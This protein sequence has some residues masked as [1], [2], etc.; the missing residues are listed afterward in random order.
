M[1]HATIRKSGAQRGNNRGAPKTKRKAWHP[2][3]AWY[4]A[5]VENAADAFFL[6]DFEGRYLAV[7]NQACKSLGYA[8]EELLSM[9]VTDVEMEYTL[10]KLKELWSSIPD[11]QPV[12]VEGHHRRKDGSLFDIEARIVPA[13]IGGERLYLV[14]IR[15]IA[16]RRAAE[17]RMALT[18]D[19]LRITEKT[20]QEELVRLKEFA[21]GTI[22]GL[23]KH[24]CVL[25][26]EGTIL[27]VNRA[28]RQFADANP[29][30]PADYFLGANYL[31]VCERV[32]GEGA[33]DAHAVAKGLRGVI[34]GLDP[35]FV[36]EYPCHRP[37]GEQ[38]W[39][40]MKATRFGGDGPV[41]LVVSHDDI[42]A[43]KRAEEGL[44]RSE[45]LLRATGKIA[46][47]GGWEL[48][49]ATMTQEWTDETYAIHDRERG[50]Y[51][52]NSS[53]ELSRFRPG[54]KELM[55]Q[56]FR[57]ALE[58]GKP[59][60]LE[61][62]MTT[63]KGRTKWVRAVC[64]PLVENGKVV[65][66]V[67]TVQDVTAAKEAAE[68]LKESEERFSTAFF[69]SPVSQS[70]I[71]QNGNEIMAVNDSCCHLFGYSREELVGANSGMLDLWQNAGDRLAAV[72]ELR[73]TGRLLPRE[74]D[75]RLKS[76]EVRTVIVAIEPIRWKGV[77]CLLTSEFDIT[78][79]K[80][81][82]LEIRSANERLRMLNEAVK[83]LAAARSLEEILALV[84]VATR[85]LARS[86]GSTFIVREG[87]LCHYL[88]EDAIGPLWKG[89]RF[90]ADSCIGGWAM[91]H[92]Q[93]VAIPD[94]R[95]DE[96]IVQ[97]RYA[98]TFVRSL[99]MVPI[100]GSEPLGAIGA[101]WSTVHAPAPME[102]QL[103]ETLA[104]AAAI[105]FE[106]VSLVDGLE[107]RVAERTAQLK[108]VNSEL[109][110]F[111]YS[112]SH[113]LRAPLRHVDGFIGLMEKDLEASGSAKTSRYMKI[114]AESSQRMGRLIDDLLAFSR[115]GRQAMRIVEVDMNAVVRD[116][117]AELH[118]DAEGRTIEWVFANLPKVSG[119]PSLLRLVF[120]NLISNAVKF[121]RGTAVARI[122][123]GSTRNGG[124][125]TTFF[126]KD[127][128]AGFDMEYAGK[129]FGVFQRLHRQ[130]DFE[131]TGIGLANVRRIILRHGGRTW[132]EGHV[133]EGA[134][135]Y[136]TIPD[137]VE[138]HPA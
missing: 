68:A 54:S 66:L 103:L 111:A 136:F 96:R 73:R 92:R 30:V 60:D 23:S 135:L 5:L 16:E 117:I 71:A 80:R 63:V 113:D 14:L 94:I 105:A 28:W 40:L 37:E 78:E 61:A 102:I 99:V 50:V 57:Q 93:T 18:D 11:G 48:N 62:E 49:V 13:K 56:A 3:T 2:R 38:R 129:L 67:G 44:R 124:E 31:D 69:T 88:D 59:Y 115:M 33:E 134:T 125:E 70:I 39:F 116:A 52:P 43:R 91:I 127:N 64:S 1:T 65:K 79:R 123:V 106:N 51:D 87:E 42:T 55:E 32:V 9:K 25:D 108:A 12:T 97:E 119:D 45:G 74:T 107:Q 112:V 27:S 83:D 6:H 128:G 8:E 85:R 89:M 20:A 126:V 34:R 58:E 137:R 35:I 133:G 4:R 109:E 41:R 29:P 101:Y 72:E 36:T 75:V 95:L 22:D 76:G 7:N 121:S 104:D 114:I 118:S 81:A 24:L 17:K 15:D 130:E 110:S 132:A 90:P 10:E 84:R 77:P 120:D 26:E 98:P 19:L 47:I 122:E 46:K 53:E 82:E 131:G 138:V 21:Q 86:D 100:R